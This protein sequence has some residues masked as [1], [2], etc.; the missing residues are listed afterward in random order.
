MNRM[1][2]CKR[3]RWWSPKLSPRW[4]RFWR[5]FQRY[6]QLRQHRL[7]EV[8]VRGLENLRGALQRGCGVLIAPNHS[9]HADCHALL[10]A[11][12]EA[13]CPF[14][15]MVAWQVFQRGNWIRRMALRHYGCFSVDR[16]GTDHRAVRQAVE[17]LQSSPHPLVIFPEG[18]VYHRNER[19]T[20]FREGPAA[21]AR[22]AARR[23]ERPVV[24]VP[25]SI[26]YEYLDDPTED[27]LDVMDRLERAVFW[28]PRPDLPLE[29]RI[30]RLAEALLGLKEYEYLGRTTEGTVPERIAVL[31]E[32][33]LEGIERRYGIE[34]G[35]ATVPERVKALR[36]AAIE[37]LEALVSEKGSDPLNRGGLTPFPARAELERDLDDLFFVVQLLSYPGDYV[38]Q[39]PSLERIA[40]TLDKFEEDVLGA[41]TATIRGTRKA[42]VTFGEPIPLEKQR[43]R[44]ATGPGLTQKLEER[45]QALLD[46]AGEETRALLRNPKSQIRNPKQTPNVK[47]P[48]T[49]TRPVADMQPS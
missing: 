39:R 29:K 37:R 9:A 49:E 23:A 20:P 2:L 32:H 47:F 21:I 8:E 26:H 40:E 17:I 42:I 48:M 35:G 13:E 22:L 43:D 14:H 12:E 1:P 34:G 11:S 30:Y 3:P 31:Q 33:V 45:V 15:F 10:R 5:I 18:E 19:I 24:C 38:A 6:A 46:G 16:E 4:I 28:R 36:K 25:C 41:S 44:K 27:L 7:I